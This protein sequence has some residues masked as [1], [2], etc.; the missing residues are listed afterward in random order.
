M[1]LNQL[2][3]YKNKTI[4]ELKLIRDEMKEICEFNQKRFIEMVT[5]KYTFDGDNMN[6]YK[7]VL[8]LI[9]QIKLGLI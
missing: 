8:S 6:H 9:N 3:V 7:E 5:F 1:I 4:D 2:E